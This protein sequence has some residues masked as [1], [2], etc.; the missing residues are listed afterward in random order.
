[1][2]PPALLADILDANSLDSM[3]DSE[4]FIPEAMLN[5]LLG[6]APLPLPLTTVHL[7]CRSGFFL[8]TVQL[9]LRG[10]GVPLRPRVQQMFELERLRFDSLNQF[11]LLRPRGGLHINEGSVGRRRLSPVARALLTTILH[12]PTLLKLVRDRFPDNVVYEHGR[13][14]IDLSNIE[15][16]TGVVTKST[17][18]GHIDLQ[19]LKY[20]NIHDVDIRKGAIVL[21]YRFEKERLLDAL[22]EA[23]PEGYYKHNRPPR[24][25]SRSERLLPPPVE[26]MQ[27]SKAEKALRLGTSIAGRGAR[28]FRRIRDRR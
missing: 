9:D 7:A 11:I 12:T 1:M 15:A 27:P 5:R 10:Q 3:E 19:I 14:H 13:M 8:L 20:L 23:P 25:E 22:R 28:L 4:L 16:I 2:Q 26:R 24:A 21:R 17:A 18:I 6:A